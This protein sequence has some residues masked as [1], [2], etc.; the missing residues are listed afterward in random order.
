MR[1]ISHVAI[2]VRDIE[3]SL[4]FYRDLLGL[5]VSLD[6]RSRCAV[7]SGCSPSRRKTAAARS[8]SS[9]SE[10]NSKTNS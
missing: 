1:G 10:T 9:K 3:R 4:S 5:T 6:K 7:R 8:I 2:G